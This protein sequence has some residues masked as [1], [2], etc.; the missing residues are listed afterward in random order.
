MSNPVLRELGFAADDRVV[1]LHAD[2]VGLCGASVDA[3]FELA[4]GELCVSGSAMVPCASFAEVAARCRARDDVDI[5]V[6]LTL[7][8][9]WDGYRWGPLST[10]DRASG[11]IDDDEV[12]ERQRPAGVVLD[13]PVHAALVGEDA[14]AGPELRQVVVQHQVEVVLAAGE[15]GEVVVHDHVVAVPQEEQRTTVTLQLCPQPSYTSARLWL[16]YRWSGAPG[17]RPLRRY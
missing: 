8:S 7:T 9:E 10:C 17:T 11:L 3:F 14:A 12:V 6:H 2:D 5:G 13:G 1:L 4:D 16:P 15:A